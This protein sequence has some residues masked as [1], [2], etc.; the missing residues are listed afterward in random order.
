MKA[1]VKW[2]KDYVDITLSMAEIANRLTMAGL[3]VGEMPKSGNWENVIVGE[4]AA[5]N[6]HPNADRLHLATVNL[7]N[8]S[9]TVVCG[10]PNLTPGDKIAF[11]R[12]GAELLD[13]HNGKQ[14]RLKPAKIRGV[15]SSGM[16]CSEQELG[17]SDSHEGILI[18]PAAAPV[19]AALDD[20]LGDVVL[21]L[22]V[23]PNRPDCLSVIGI[24]REIAALTGESL[25]LPEVGYEEAEPPV[26]QR[27]TVEITAPELCPRYC[28]SL[29]TDIKIGD[30]PEWL[31]QRLLAYGMRPINNVVDITNYVMLEYGQPLHAFDYDK[32]S[33][34]KIIVRR[35]AKAESMVSLDGVARALTPDMLVIADTKQAVALAG[36]MGGA[37]SEVTGQTTSIL[38]ESASFKPSSIYYTG[39]ALSLTSEASM[40]FERGIRAELT[41]PA[42]KRATQLLTQLTGGQAAAG[43]IDIFPGKQERQPV[44]LSPQ[45]VKRLLGVE[46]SL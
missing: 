46:F 5:V 2:L 16:I 44:R 37:D 17:I 6:P 34:G 4:I 1:S 27:V 25:H 40:R 15:E 12:V 38:L 14:A 31:Q 36:V 21:D 26:E 22:E 32:I 8:E 41:L 35:A 10:A 24:A 3:E 43:V 33:N 13:A 9:Q 18:L 28:A 42:L 30:S 20:Y 23:T 39:R 11:A 29:V 45:E 19:G 7:G